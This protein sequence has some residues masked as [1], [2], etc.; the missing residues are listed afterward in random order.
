ML[1]RTIFGTIT[2][3][4]QK[5]ESEL[6]MEY[7]CDLTRELKGFDLEGSGIPVN[8]EFIAD[9]FLAFI[10][11]YHVSINDFVRFLKDV[12]EREETK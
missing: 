9:L 3:N 1:R 5:S 6:A 10:E 8:N 4:P 2:N 11:K 7:I 12:R